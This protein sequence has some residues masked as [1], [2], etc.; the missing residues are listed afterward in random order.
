[1][2]LPEAEVA[3]ASRLL[4]LSPSPAVSEGGRGGSALSA[5]RLSLHT[6][7]AC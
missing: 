7:L 6:D 2:N 1:M 4:L 3:E 5:L